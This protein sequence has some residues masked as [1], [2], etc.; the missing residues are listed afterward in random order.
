MISIFSASFSIDFALLTASNV[1][2]VEL[3]VIIVVTEV[4]DLVGVVLMEEAIVVGISEDGIV[5]VTA[6]FILFSVVV[7]SVAEVGLQWF[8]KENQQSPA[9]LVN[10][11]FS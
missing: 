4:V 1:A 9:Y 7:S 5:S 8:A 10:C 6:F 2:E 11:H 3:E